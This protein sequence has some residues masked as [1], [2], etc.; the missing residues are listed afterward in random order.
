MYGS[1]A[2]VFA[3]SARPSDSCGRMVSQRCSYISSD[4]LLGLPPISPVPLFFLRIVKLWL[5]CRF[6]SRREY[7]R[8][9]ALSWSRRSLLRVTMD[10]SQWSAS[11]LLVN[12]RSSRSEVVV[13]P[14]FSCVGEL[15][16]VSRSAIT[17]SRVDWTL[18]VH[19]EDIVAGSH[20]S[21][22]WKLK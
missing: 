4:R 10:A 20:P 7:S 1:T 13:L 21:F 11:V 9:G 3:S 18:P 12:P 14:S 17:P 8:E 5:Q 2:V 6:V 22:G 19:L 16:P 15:V